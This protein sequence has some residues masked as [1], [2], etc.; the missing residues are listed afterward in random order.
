MSRRAV[1]AVVIGDTAPGPHRLD[2][3]PSGLPVSHPRTGLD[4]VTVALVLAFIT[5]TA[6]VVGNGSLPVVD[7]WVRTLFTPVPRDGLARLVVLAVSI[8]A[9]AQVG[10]GLLLLVG[11]AF[12]LVRRSWR[13]AVLAWATAGALLVSVLFTKV[14]VD[15][16]RTPT[17]IVDPEPAYPSGHATTALVAYGVVVL[18]LGISSPQVRRWAWGAV[19]LYAVLIGVGRVYLGAHWAS[20]VLA[21]WLLG[22]II[23]TL[24]ARALPWSARAPGTGP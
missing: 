16:F 7:D 19:A 20:D 17:G 4:T 24:V 15:R 18:L 13:P 14:L 10:V 9:S 21:G 8:G 5:L 11:G 22:G 12:A 23:L 6:I 2:Q 1:D 3:R